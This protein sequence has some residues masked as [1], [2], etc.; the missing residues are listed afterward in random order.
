MPTGLDQRAWFAALVLVILTALFAA[1][2]LG[3]PIEYELDASGRWMLINAPEEGTDAALIAETRRLL[4]EGRA[5]Q[6]RAMISPWIEANKRRDNPFLPQAYLLRGDALTL[7]NDE[8]K[9]LYDYEAIITQFPNSEEFVT[10]VERELEIAIRYVNGYKRKW[11][12]MRVIDSSGL[13]AEMLVRVAERLPGST[14]AERAMI[15]YADH[16]YRIRN[17]EH[18][19]EAYDLFLQLHPKSQFRRHA[20]ERLVYSQVGSFG[21]PAY[22][23]KG[24]LEADRLIQD[25]G[26]RFPA[27]AQR[28]GLDDALRARLDESAAAKLLHQARW[29]LRRDDPVAAR[30]TLRQLI[31]KH[32]GT[33][34]AE[35][36]MDM[37]DER[38]WLYEAPAEDDAQ[39]P[40]E[41]P[42]T[43]DEP[44]E[45]LP[46]DNQPG[47]QAP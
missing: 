15:E 7:A 41:P 9:A 31:R 11:L 32:P 19:A 23:G 21:G 12:G 26:R 2:A 1:P 33:V 6:A 42:A 10:A 46:A 40:P 47:D 18:A 8:F 35:T 36:A 45:G 30:Y 37:M 25:F 28:A 20:M 43:E 34:A 14:L 13:G 39:P 17:M 22:S 27:D 24:L 16:Y 4:A 3:Q 5:R 38:Q 29:Y 44:V